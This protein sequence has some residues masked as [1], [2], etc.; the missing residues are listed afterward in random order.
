MDK[1][2]NEKFVKNLQSAESA[3]SDTCKERKKFFGDSQTQCRENEEVAKTFQTNLHKKNQRINELEEALKESVSITAER[4][5][6]IAQ[7][8]RACE[9]L[10]EKIRMYREQALKFHAMHQETDQKFI[11]LK[12]DYQEKQKTICGF[13]AERKQQLEEVLQLKLCTGGLTLLYFIREEY[14]LAAISEKDAHIA[15]LENGNL[16]AEKVD[17]IE[18]LRLHKEKLMKR[19]KAEN[20]KRLELLTLDFSNAGA[21]ADDFAASK[22]LL[23]SL[24]SVPTDQKHVKEGRLYIIRNPIFRLTTKKASG[25]RSCSNEDD[26]NWAFMAESNFRQFFMQFFKTIMAFKRLI[27]W[28]SGEKS[29]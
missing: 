29:E 19:L 3:S 4:E 26:Q 7:Q 27:Q 20:A 6:V 13:G 22:I 8:K 28:F 9:I 24:K 21:S 10:E 5:M 25:R 14:L 16:A 17:E 12:K 1:D 11:N 18:T 15:L 23:E 2:S